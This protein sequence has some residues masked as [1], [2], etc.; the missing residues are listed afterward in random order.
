MEVKMMNFNDYTKDQQR[1]ITEYGNNI[2]V[3]AGAGSGKT[4]VLT[5]RVVH[6]I[7]EKGFKIQDFLIVTFT[8]LAA[9]EMKN[10]IRK[11]LIKI[12]S[13]EADKVDQAAIS[14]FDSYALSLVKKYHY[15]L[16]VSKDVSIVNENLITLKKRKILRDMFEK[17]YLLQD[18]EFINLIDSL[19][20]KTDDEIIDIIIS[21]DRKVQQQ[22]DSIGYLNNLVKDKYGESLCKEIKNHSLKE[23]MNLRKD[24]LYLM[25]EMDD[26]IQ[27]SSGQPLSE[28]L[29]ENLR[30]F[31]EYESYDDLMKPLNLPKYKMKKASKIN[32]IAKKIIGKI[33]HYTEKV[34][35]TEVE[36]S[37]YVKEVARYVAQIV[38][39]TLELNEQ[40][41]MYKKEHNVFEFNDIQKMAFN[42]VRENETIKE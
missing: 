30:D 40:L 8:V 42:L 13:E 36:V 3:S 10:R 6:F 27:V 31:F 33:N 4:Q 35:K 17:Y 29:R 16:N 25:D 37:Q 32:D 39:L 34:P 41:M 14:T 22:I 23:I 19:C 15:Y 28:F 24:L 5:E 18:A 26:E 9:G 38:R 20:F 21:F 7:K 11:E 12:Q 2:L 1:A